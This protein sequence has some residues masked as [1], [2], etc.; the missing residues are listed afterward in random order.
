MEVLWSGGIDSTSLTVALIRA[1]RQLKGSRTHSY[2]PDLIMKVSAASILEYPWFYQHVLQPAEVAGTLRLETIAEGEDISEVMSH[3]RLTITGECGDQIFVSQLMEAAFV[4]PTAGG[5]PHKL[6][7]RGLDAPWKETILPTLLEM[8]ILRPSDQEEWLRWFEP[9]LARSPLP[10]NTSFDLLWWLNITCKWQ[11][12]V[13]R[14][15]QRRPGLD[16]QS[17]QHGLG[18][19][20]H[21][22]QSAAFQQWSFV[23][24]NHAAKMADTSVWSTYKQPLKQYIFDFTGDRAY[25]ENKLKEGSLC[26]VN[27][28]S[29]CVILVIDSAFNVIRFGACCL[30]TCQMERKYPGK[31]LQRAFLQDASAT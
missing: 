3:D 11:N 6:Y 24:A 4:T 20:I 31:A 12:V 5:P 21:F 23:P 26:K 15:F 29:E 17:L 9:F 19:V 30:N 10:I 22:F 16:A 1:A 2:K 28:A 8:G 7:E 13:L 27:D 14:I 18:R 25:F